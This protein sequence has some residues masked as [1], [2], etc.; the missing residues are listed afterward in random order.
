MAPAFHIQECFQEEVSVW[1]PAETAG[2]EQKKVG[3]SLS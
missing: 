2:G 1:D 3:P